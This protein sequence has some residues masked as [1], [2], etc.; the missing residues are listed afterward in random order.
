MEFFDYQAAKKAGKTDEQIT[1]FLKQQKA[2]GRDLRIR[3]S[4]YK[5]T[6]APAQPVEPKKDIL[7]TIT[8]PI[9]T[10]VK[11]V[12][13]AA[14]LTGIPYLVGGA[15][16]LLG[17]AIGGATAAIGNPIANLIQGKPLLQNFKQEVAANA[18][19][20]AQLGYEVGKGGAE[21]APLGALGRIP[22]GVL[23]AAQGASGIK[24]SIEAVKEGDAV[25]G[26]QAATELAGGAMGLH[27]ALGA[28]LLGKGQGLWLNPDVVGPLKETVSNIPSKLKGAAIE[29]LKKMQSDVA[30]KI[31]RLSPAKSAKEVQWGK[32][33]PQLLADEGILQ[34]IEKDGNKMNV[35]KAVDALDTVSGAENTAFNNVLRDTGYSSLNEL[36]TK[37]IEQIN[38]GSYR[39]RGT[40][41]GDAVKYI[42][43]S[44]AALK[45]NYKDNG[46]VILENGDVILPNDVFNNVK[47]GFWDKTGF[48]MN[49]SDILKSDV[50]YALGHTAKEII[51]KNVPDANINR[52]NN[53]LGDLAAAKKALWGAQGKVPVGGVMGKWFATLAGGA[54]L[55]QFGP[56][57][58]LV[59]GLTGD[60][61]AGIM[62]DPKYSAGAVSALLNKLG[63][64]K[65]GYNLVQEAQAVLD[66]RGAERA[67][68]PLLKAPSFIPL[69]GPKGPVQGK[70]ASQAEATALLRKQG[71]LNEGTNKPSFNY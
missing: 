66:A 7:D 64:T 48:S 21:T 14:D 38:K 53:R 42:K 24:H 6:A 22:S 71:F 33:S 57:G 65:E 69:N 49:K 15:A 5:G 61:L 8:S 68:R 19:K 56:L 20:T 46:A 67:A 47:K 17:G 44:V 58:K 31:V 45:E 27:G 50:D 52:M 60:K 63:S 13:K 26:A 16:G 70:V 1:G 32:N 43:D 2:A 55:S 35:Q 62:T 51:Q 41:Y 25:K 34:L 54:L 28:P 10:A 30:N 29:P 3:E 39:A 59:G 23:A 9:N 4:D 18:S 12:G 11:T 37:A 36:E 40:D